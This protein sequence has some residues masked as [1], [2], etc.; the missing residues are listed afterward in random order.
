MIH[1]YKTS[2]ILSLTVKKSKPKSEEIQQ[3]NSELAHNKT[4]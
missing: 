2:N 3:G 1:M 4:E